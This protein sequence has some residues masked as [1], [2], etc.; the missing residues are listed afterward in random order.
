ML[1]PFII[2]FLL[3]T[4]AAT[5]RIV[6]T[7]RNASLNVD[8]TVP[9]NTTVVKQYGRRMVLSV[10]SGTT[11]EWIQEALGGSDCVERIEPDAL[12]DTAYFSTDSIHSWWNM[13]ESEPYSI[14]THS[15][16]TNGSGVVIAI[17]DSGLA[18]AAKSLFRPVGGFDFISSADYSNKP[19]QARNPDYTDPGDQGPTCPT[20]SW[21]GTKVSSI[22]MAL[23]PGSTLTVMRVLG[24]CG[25]G[26]SSDIADA[27]VWAA[28]GQING[29]NPNPFPA[30]VISMSL[31]GK[32]A[33]PSY[34]QSA[35]NQ[36]ISLGSTVIAAAGNAAQNVS[37]YFPANCKG[38]VAVGASTR[39][40]TLASY[41]NWGEGLTFSA[42]G[43]DA[44]NPIPYITVIDNR[45]IVSWGVGTSFAAPHA[46]GMVALLR[47][48]RLDSVGFVPFVRCDVAVCGSILSYG[49]PFP[50][51]S[52]ALSVML[53]GVGVVN[54]S[55][56]RASQTCDGSLSEGFWTIQAGLGH[57]GDSLPPNYVC[58]YPCFINYIFACTSGAVRSLKVGCSDGT[59]SELYGYQ[60]A[61]DGVSDNIASSKGFTGVKTYAGRD[62]NGM[63]VRA[64]DGQTKLFGCDGCQPLSDLQCGLAVDKQPMVLSGIWIATDSVWM[65]AFAFYCVK[66]TCSSTSYYSNNDCLSCGWCTGANQYSS[67][68]GGSSAGTCT[69]CGACADKQ[70]RAGCGSNSGGWCTDCGA[71]DAGKSF[72]SCG[73]SA[74]YDDH[75][76]ADCG[77]GTYSPGGSYRTCIGC[78]TG[79]YNPNSGGGSL[80]SCQLCPIG[81]YNPVTSSISISACSACLAG[82][83]GVSDG[84]S[85]E[86]ECNLCPIGKYNPSS[87]AA[88]SSSCISCPAGTFSDTAGAAACLMCGAGTY[89]AETGA[90]SSACTPCQEGTY[91]SG[92][93][94]NSVGACTPCSQ[95]K[96]NAA[97]GKSSIIACLSCA[98]GTF[99]SST[100][101]GVCVSCGVGKFNSALGSAGPCTKCVAGTYSL[102]LGVAACTKCDPGAFSTG[103]GAIECSKCVA[104]QFTA[105]TGS[106]ACTGCALTTYTDVSGSTTCRPCPSIGACAVGSEF[107]CV[108][109]SGSQCVA[110]DYIYGCEY[111]TNA[112]FLNDDI[113]TPSCQ[114][115]AG[116]EMKAGGCT[117]C[118]PGY[119]KAVQGIQPCGALLTPTCS[120]N[121]FL[122][123]GTA[124]IDSTCTQCPQLPPGSHALMGCEWRCDA[125]YDDNQPLV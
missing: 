78:R 9:D 68:C 55:T 24:Q 49:I 72:S 31:A 67:G 51:R 88:Y 14:H 69:A 48:L 76:C 86:S 98:S 92:M 37:L 90:V 99:A 19:S 116:F 125:G 12:V 77:P 74:T 59:Y 118:S 94:M 70:Y 54:S 110:C 17:V 39:Q 121:Y 41:S 100:G 89:G 35:V 8:A 25:V 29:L 108:A 26:F 27:V 33:C 56:A 52:S 101:M 120:P 102:A 10:G 13:D 109:T 57:G 42:P 65:H 63:Q 79:R 21:H 123:L 15:L 58:N 32:S 62:I 85:L 5:P 22:A 105:T 112:C 111:T 45:L 47:S 93:G 43:G 81:K 6:I 50:N 2:I 114:C 60:S 66:R 53:G 80:A 106:V 34:L 4:T 3:T 11:E 16:Q 23:A 122:V 1:P 71:C 30:S 84:A 83:F 119:F 18:D 117:G 95:G 40:G 124:Y 64:M 82:K 7:F 96:Y 97:N 28:G 107:R 103:E 87:S 75:T 20:P 115:K 73:G 113:T 36:A 38:V 61:C 104:G 46:A 44:M 91:S